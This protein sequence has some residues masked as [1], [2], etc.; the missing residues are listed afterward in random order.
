MEVRLATSKDIN[1]LVRLRIDFLKDEFGLSS[2]EETQIENHLFSYFDRHL[3]ADSFIAVLVTDEYNILSTA[4]LTIHEKP[5]NLSF[6]NGLSGTL[7]N[8]FTYPQYRKNGYATK[9]VTSI[10]EEAQKRNI[11]V[12]DL[13]ATTNGLAIY[14]RLGFREISNTAMRLKLG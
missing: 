14:S 11:S 3:L 8:V 1:Q 6:M 5:A 13:S 12:I 4:F 2:D 9:A 10:I 7:L